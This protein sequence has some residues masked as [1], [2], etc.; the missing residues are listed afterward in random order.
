MCSKWCLESNNG[1]NDAGTEERDL[2]GEGDGGSGDDESP[3]H[4]EKTDNSNN[5]NESLNESTYDED[6]N[7]DESDDGFD[8]VLTAEPERADASERAHAQE[9]NENDVDWRSGSDWHTGAPEPDHVATDGDN[10]TGSETV[11]KC[12]ADD[13]IRCSKNPHVL[14]CDIQKC[15]GHADCPNGEDEV[16]CKIGIFF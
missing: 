6:E 2:F 3:I 8:L 15:D 11:N 5:N 16:D 9:E 14:I 7:V 12:R 1:T 4:N 13:T 10:R